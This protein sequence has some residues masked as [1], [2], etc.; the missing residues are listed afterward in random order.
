MIVDHRTLAGAPPVGDSATTVSVI[1]RL[2]LWE[3]AASEHGELEFH[4]GY[5]ND[6]ADAL[7]RWPVNPQEEM[8]AMIRDGLLRRVPTA[9]FDENSESESTRAST[10]SSSPPPLVD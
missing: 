3:H 6:I 1:S 10:G 7:S 2:L 8:Y 9:D 4:P 5:Y